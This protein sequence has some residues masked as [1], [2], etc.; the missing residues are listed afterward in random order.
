MRA[1]AAAQS[2]VAK[3]CLLQL[4]ST[5]RKRSPLV[6]AMAM[7]IPQ[8]MAAPAKSRRPANGKRGDDDGHAMS[9]NLSVMHDDDGPLACTTTRPSTSS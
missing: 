1:T 6:M 3:E 4:S 9:D 5:L 2:D 8:V 7:V